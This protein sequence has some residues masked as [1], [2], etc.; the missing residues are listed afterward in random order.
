MVSAR[1]KKGALRNALVTN[2]AEF[3][4]YEKHNLHLLDSLER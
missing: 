3:E 4:S 1:L 2:D